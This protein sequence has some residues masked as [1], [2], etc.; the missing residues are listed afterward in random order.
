MDVTS[1]GTW[2]R[3]CSY[4][5][6]AGVVESVLGASLSFLWVLSGALS[7]SHWLCGPPALSQGGLSGSDGGGVGVDKV[8]A[9]G[10]SLRSTSGPTSGWVLA[11]RELDGSTG[12]FW[13][14]D[15]AGTTLVGVVVSVV[16]SLAG[17]LCAVLKLSVTELVAVEGTFTTVEVGSTAAGLFGGKEQRE[18]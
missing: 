8:E 6:W 4:S 7:G 9:L 17:L 5:F 13:G 3:W 16:F 11:L 14:E 12:L 18:G 10:V 1:G 2:K 15:L